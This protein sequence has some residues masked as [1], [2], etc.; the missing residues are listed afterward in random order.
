MTDLQLFSFGEDGE[1]GVIHY[2][3]TGQTLRWVRID[4][5]VRLHFGDL[6]KGTGHSNP[7]AAI[8]LIEDEDK[9]KLDMNIVF[10]GQ[11]ALR[12]VRAGTTSGNSEAWFVN[13]DGFATLGL[14]GRGD[15][16]RVFR[17]WIVK[18]VLP[19]FRRQQAEVS[20]TDLAR[21]V[22]E[23]AAE[24]DKA[25]AELGEARQALEIA[26]PKADYVDSFV[27]A[28]SDACT[29]RVLANQLKVREKDLRELLVE[30][31]A[32][33][34]RLEGSRW[35]RTQSR[36]VAEYSWHAYATHKAWFTEQDQPEAPRLHNG[37]MRT[38]L[39]VTPVGKVKIAGLMQKRGIA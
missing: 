20:R 8:N 11:S 23:E 3:E 17:R 4:G 31:K 38:T 14:A 32:I 9:I 34:R 36:H 19:R 12:N 37:Q 13:E 26:G 39:Y 24:K 22:L 21:M 2:P 16:P 10:P 7:S 28:T 1:S 5:V 30:K 29:I 18:V 6:C 27:H 35:S 15:G 33:Y 25:L